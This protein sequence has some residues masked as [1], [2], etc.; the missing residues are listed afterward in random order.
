[1][2]A[3]AWAMAFASELIGAF[4]GA[5]VAGKIARDGARLVCG[6]IVGAALLGSVANW[7]A[8]EHPMWFM[9]GQ[10]VGYPLVLMGVWAMVGRAGDVEASG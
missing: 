9:A 7:V 5:F 8:F 1:M 10:L 2:P 6:I 4:A 3:G